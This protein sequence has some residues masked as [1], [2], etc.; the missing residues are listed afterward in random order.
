[1]FMNLLALAGDIELH[2]GPGQ[3]ALLPLLK[4]QQEIANIV[5]DIQSRRCNI[6]ANFT[7]LNECLFVLENKLD[8][9]CSLLNQV[10]VPETE[11]ALL[12]H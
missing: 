6:G 3:D 4:G 2:P 5:T 8:E 7:N 1:M 9:F 11:L 12:S 10:K